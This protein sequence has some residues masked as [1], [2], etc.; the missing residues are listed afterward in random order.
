MGEGAGSCEI[1]RQA[2]IA[3]G[4]LRYLSDRM[5]GPEGLNPQALLWRD[6]MP[7]DGA[8]IFSDL[9]GTSSTQGSAMVGHIDRQP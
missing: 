2:L 3:P 5:M 7:R 4:L 9:I 6:L 8:I 1:L